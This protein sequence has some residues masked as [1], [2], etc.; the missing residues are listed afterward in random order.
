MQ[1]KRVLREDRVRKVPRSFSWVDHRLIR[2]GHIRHCDAA[3]LA[4]YLFLISVSDVDGISYYYDHSISRMLQLTEE[5][6]RK[7][8]QS[9]LDA[10][11]VAYDM[12]LYQVLSI[13]ER[14][15]A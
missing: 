14:R 4:L 6:L 11:L 10:D 1:E 15:Q 9:L 13:P 12:P 3:A 7:A 5:K 2:E 8:R